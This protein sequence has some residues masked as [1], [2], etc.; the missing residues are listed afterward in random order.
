M[1][2]TVV[3]LGM[4]FWTCLVFHLHH[5]VVHDNNV[6]NIQHFDLKRISPYRSL[7][8][9][10][11]FRLS[12]YRSRSIRSTLLRSTELSSAVRP[13]PF[14]TFALHNP[15]LFHHLRL[16]SSSVSTRSRR[17]VLPLRRPRRL[18]EGL[19]GVILGLRLGIRGDPSVCKD[20]AERAEIN[21][22]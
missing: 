15:I 3:S 1:S 10:K 5:D 20:E 4:N 22:M 16:S 9:L 21:A 19:W 11:P 7:R 17:Y 12:L 14:P 2:T 13:R 18:S 8:Y 6:S